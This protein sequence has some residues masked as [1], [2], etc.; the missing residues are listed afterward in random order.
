MNCDSVSCCAHDVWIAFAPGWDL[1]TTQ[2]RSPLDVV[3]ALTHIFPGG[4]CMLMPGIKYLQ[5]MNAG[6]DV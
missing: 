1:I 3:F 5:Q 4:H 2:A 6:V